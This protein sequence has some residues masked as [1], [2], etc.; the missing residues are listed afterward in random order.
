VRSPQAST[1][2][3][4]EFSLHARR[5]T[6]WSGS[7]GLLPHLIDT[8]DCVLLMMVRKGIPLTRQN[9]FDLAY[10]DGLPE[11]W[12]AELESELPDVIQ[13]EP[14]LTQQHERLRKKIR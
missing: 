10:P 8:S 4:P 13:R 9:Y 12:G 1:S 3:P 5:S 7:G 2:K 14:L 11:D 6:A